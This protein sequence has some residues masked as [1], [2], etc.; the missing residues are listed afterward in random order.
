MKG[1]VLI[2]YPLIKQ[3]LLVFHLVKNLRKNG[4]QVDAINST[5]FKFVEAP[6][7][8]TSIRFKLIT[9]LCNLP[10]P[11]IKGLLFKSGIIN[12]EKELQNIA[13][14]YE[15][16][17]FHCVTKSYDN[18]ILKLKDEKIIKVS[19]WGSDFYRA[20][21]KRREEQRIILQNCDCIQISTKAMKN[22]FFNYFRDFEEKIRVANFGLYQFETISEVE[23]LESAPVFKT[24]Q[25]AK[26]LMLVCGYNGSEGQQHRIIIE[27]ISQL[28]SYIKEKVFLV[29]PMTYGASKDYQEEIENSL[30]DL[31]ISFF[32]I[33]DYLSNHEVAKLRIETDIVI[34]IQ[35]TDAFSG[36]LQE[37][38][39]AN[40]L[41]LAGDWLPYGLLDESHVFYKKSTMGD[42]TDKIRDCILNFAQYKALTS[43]NRAKMNRISSWEFAGKRISK[44]YHDLEE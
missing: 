24:E 41:L 16:I 33:K 37:H 28:N 14:N 32:I 36:S 5:N 23:T 43:C 34:N 3:E 13:E 35:K 30:K 42:L 17:D 20:D 9:F 1:R 40:N 6:I 31:N 11:K 7:E 15:L 39:F 2:I 27:S 29:F 18:L 19:F 8:K 4:V 26:K 21:K 22:D 44:I 38:L 12:V 10:I 25:H